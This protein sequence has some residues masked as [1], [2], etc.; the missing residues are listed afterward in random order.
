MS[1][2]YIFFLEYY[3]I[4]IKCLHY[5]ATASHHKFGKPSFVLMTHYIIIFL[6]FLL[7]P[8]SVSVDGGV[9]ICLPMISGYIISHFIKYIYITFY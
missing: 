5:I 7:I 2:I 9:I 3:F 6:V 4:C 1:Y 8:L